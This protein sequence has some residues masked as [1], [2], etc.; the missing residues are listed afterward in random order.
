MGNKS[1][2]DNGVLAKWK[3]VTAFVYDAQVMKHLFDQ[4]AMRTVTISFA[5]NV[6]KDKRDAWTSVLP[7]EEQWTPGREEKIPSGTVI[8]YN[9]K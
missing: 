4:R 7:N 5:A 2:K 8:T 6:T 9:K 3:K 1:R